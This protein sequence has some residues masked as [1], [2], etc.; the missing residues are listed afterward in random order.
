MA[1]IRGGRSFASPFAPPK[2]NSVGVQYYFL[3]APV[4]HIEIPLSQV[5][6]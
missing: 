4:V 3:W 6:K 2:M 1:F 5:T